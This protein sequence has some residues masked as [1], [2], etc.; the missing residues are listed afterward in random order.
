MTMQL[1]PNR[2][3]AELADGARQWI[4]PGTSLAFSALTVVFAPMYARWFGDAM[5]GARA[6]FSRSIRSGS[7]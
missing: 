1:A 4:A 6:G 3:R 2:S 5:P 7:C